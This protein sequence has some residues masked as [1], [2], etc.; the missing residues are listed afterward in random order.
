MDNNNDSFRLNDYLIYSTTIAKGSFSKILLGNNVKT[1]NEV[2]IKYINKDMA[3]KKDTVVNNEIEIM[4]EIYNDTLHINIVELIDVI[5]YNGA[6]YIITQFCNNKTLKEML[7]T[8]T[9]EYEIQNVLYQL[10]EGLKFLYNKNILHKDIKPANILLHLQTNGEITIKLCDFGF[11]QKIND[12]NAFICGTMLYIA[13]ELLWNKN[14]INSDLWSVG[15]IMFQMLYKKHPIKRCSNINEMRIAI[16]EYLYVDETCD[17]PISDECKSL[18][19]SLLEKDPDKRITWDDF[20]KHPW[21][22][23]NFTTSFKVNDSSTDDILKSVNLDNSFIESVSKMFIK[24]VKQPKVHII[25]DYYTKALITDSR[26]SLSMNIPIANP[27]VKP[28]SPILINQ[29]YIKN[30]TKGISIITSYVKNSLSKT[31]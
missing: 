24:P 29:S 5:N 23:I 3:I 25:D 19:K 12:I 22:N 8:F 1:G 2:A 28:S 16:E 13:P 15:I 30:V 27:I 31:I 4:K 21:W 7:Y 20:F 10:K 26:S 14:T 6:I 9:Y 11:S 17:I 18:L